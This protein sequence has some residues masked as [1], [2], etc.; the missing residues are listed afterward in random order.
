MKQDSPWKEA[1]ERY[2]RPF[3]QLFFPE[4]HDD[5]DW[6]K[7]YIFL[8]KELE[9][10]VRDAKAGTRRVDKLVRVHIRNGKP[11][12]ILI[13]IEIQGYGDAGFAAR[14]YIYNYR[15]F[16]RYQMPVVSLAV[17]TDT[18]PDFKP[19]EYVS[20]WYGCRLRFEF[21]VI[22]LADWREK[23]DSLEKNP[24][25]F[26]VVVMAHLKAQEFGRGKDE[27]RKKWKFYLIRMLYH[28]GYTREDILELCRFIDWLMVL[29]ED[30]EK[31]LSEELA[32]A[33][34][35]KKMPY[36]T[37]WERIGRKEGKKEGKAEGK[38][39][40][41]REMLIDAVRGRFGRV[42]RDVSR[43]VRQI[44]EF[45]VLKSLLVQAVKCH[46]L[47]SFREMLHQKDLNAA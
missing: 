30:L 13:H 28:R 3:M 41:S 20:E 10:I 32:K 19:A 27:E 46:D 36:V 16:D 17:L 29:P 38:V 6:E 24:N 34:E 11:A 15:L 37:S 21:P 14:M 5:I 25:P 45:T 2:F 8:D 44:G 22:K 35:E 26:A 33:E 12:L 4:I 9:K 47:E 31:Q 42:P 40:A 23:W 43:T 39:E 18:D 1:L 7:G